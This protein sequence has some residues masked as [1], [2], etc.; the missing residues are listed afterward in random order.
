MAHNPPNAPLFRYR[1]KPG[2]RHGVQKQHGPG[3]V[4]ELTEFEANGFSDKLQKVGPVEATKVVG[5]GPP[6]EDEDESESSDATGAAVELAAEHNLD[7]S[8]IS[9]SGD[10]GRILVGDVEAVIG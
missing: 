7:L 2:Y 6:A 9:G 8:D 4:V 3:D 1:V 10:G 5:G